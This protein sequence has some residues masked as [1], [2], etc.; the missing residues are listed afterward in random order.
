MC[1]PRS[2]ND[3]FD[4]D[5]VRECLLM[6]ILF[7]VN[8]VENILK[9]TDHNAFPVVVSKES[10]YLVGSVSRKDLSVALGT[11]F[12]CATVMSDWSFTNISVSFPLYPYY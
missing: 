11:Y 7:C 10:Q 3:Q 9:D 8:T 2:F 4:T 6:L 5:V 1:E 12:V